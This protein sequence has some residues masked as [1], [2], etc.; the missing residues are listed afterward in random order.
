[1]VAG[2]DFTITSEYMY[3]DTMAEW[4]PGPNVNGI[5]IPPL[6]MRPFF[7]NAGSVQYG[8]TF[9]MVG[10]QIGELSLRNSNMIYAFDPFL[11]DWIILPERLFEP[12]VYPSSVF[13]PDDHVN[14]N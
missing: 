8:N 9:L 3:L 6:P 14:C 1:M 2:G 10:G 13:I 4:L 7:V 11:F 12:R 5:E